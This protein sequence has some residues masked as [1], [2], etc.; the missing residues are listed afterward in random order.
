[1]T[2]FTVIQYYPKFHS[3]GVI[4]WSSIRRLPPELL[5]ALKTAFG[6]SAELNSA[7]VYMDLARLVNHQKYTQDEINAIYL[8]TLH[9][10][11]M[12]E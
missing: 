1:M 3:T 2:A 5:S 9:E 4:K 6:L 10:W 12:D 7:G 8:K 11:G